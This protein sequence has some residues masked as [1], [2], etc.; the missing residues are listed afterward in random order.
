M[1]RKLQPVADVFVSHHGPLF[2]VERGRR[3]TIQCAVVIKGKLRNPRFI[4]KNTNDT[5][6]VRVGAKT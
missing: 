4:P 1:T 5:P 3:L 2:S 6:T